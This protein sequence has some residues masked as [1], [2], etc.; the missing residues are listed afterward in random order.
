MNLFA[1]TGD[2][3]ISVLVM[4]VADSGNGVEFARS[5]KGK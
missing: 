5:E 4:S 2:E 1:F 3:N